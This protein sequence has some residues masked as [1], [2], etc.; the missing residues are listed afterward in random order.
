[1]RWPLRIPIYAVLA[2]TLFYLAAQTWRRTGEAR[3]LAR[4][5]VIRQ[6]AANPPPNLS[7][8]RL[9]ELGQEQVVLLEKAFAIE[10]ANFETSY[11]LGEIYLQRSFDAGIGFE[12]EAAR[13]TNWFARAAAVNQYLG[14]AWLGHGMAL[15]WMGR[16][17]E[18]LAYFKKGL[19]LDPH[20]ARSL[21][22][23]AWHYLQ[24]RD[25]REARKWCERSLGIIQDPRVRPNPATMLRLIE[26]RAKDDTA[27]I[28]SGTSR[29]A[30]GG[31]P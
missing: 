8:D 13:A 25:Y 7:A 24:L 10:P 6:I 1:V 18:S 20:G 22:C 21:A 9:G 3:L 12:A 27:S 30:K 28:N 26:E 17:N 5:Q 4:A 16:T 11:T 19:E 15:D 31:P 23:M 2:V 29:P 14:Y